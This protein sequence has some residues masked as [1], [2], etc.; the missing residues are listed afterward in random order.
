MTLC[1]SAGESWITRLKG[2]LNKINIYISSVRSMEC[3]IWRFRESNFQKFSRGNIRGEC[4]QNPLSVIRA[5]E[6]DSQLAFPVPSPAWCLMFMP[7][8]KKRMMIPSL[9]EGEVWAPKELHMYKTRLSCHW[10]NHEVN[11]C[12]WILNLE[13][14][15]VGIMKHWGKNDLNHEYQDSNDSA[16]TTDCLWWQQ[17]LRISIINFNSKEVRPL[18]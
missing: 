9:H 18:N 2:K 15:L 8:I 1:T 6:A 13:K 12:S 4:S 17:R 5:F 16:S 11:G 7:V 14:I 10:E 3:R